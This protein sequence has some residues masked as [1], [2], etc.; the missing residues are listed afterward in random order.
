MNSGS[1]FSGFSVSSTSTPVKE[2]KERPT[3]TAWS[4]GL[5]DRVRHEKFWTWTI[6]ALSGVIADI[7]F[8]GSPIK[9]MNLEIAPLERV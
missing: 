8:P 9:K 7:A 5:W 2:K 4:L 6:V 1:T 3:I